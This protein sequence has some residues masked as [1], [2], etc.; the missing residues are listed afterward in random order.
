MKRTSVHFGAGA[1]GRGLV[2]P[3]LVEAGWAVVVVDPLDSLLAALRRD[4]GYR[5][6][7]SQNGETHETWVPVEAALHPTKDSAA[8]A[9]HLGAVPLVTT[10]VRK[11]N[12]GSTVKQLATAWADQMPSPVT[13]VGCENVERVDEVLGAHFDA[14]GLTP[15]KRRQVTIPRTVVD[16]ICASGWPETTIIRTEP[17]AELAASGG[18]TDLPGIQSVREI[19]ATF[20]RKRYLVNT[21][22]DA[23]A[24]L[25]LSRGYTLLSEAFCDEALLRELAPL[26]DALERHLIALHGFER[27]EL[28]LYAETSRRRLAETFIP[29]RL[30]TVARDIWRKMQPGERF[31][32]PLIDLQRRGL[33]SP[34]ATGVV[35]NLV[36]V[37]SAIDGGTTADD[38]GSRLAEIGRTA[39]DADAD[40]VY[41][42][43][44]DRLEAHR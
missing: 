12:L 23:A 36:L 35:A 22:A 39:G 16:R 6:E 43:I 11:E 20:D 27:R 7:L 28:D 34:E 9:A 32:A 21:F 15:A 19:D 31:F 8:I 2:V 25:G 3:R 30:D 5:L 29:R 24:I 10:A 44:A 18:A 17:Y 14:S 40:A 4:G 38:A 33:A 41:R 26:I 13:V 42:N 1:L 37:G